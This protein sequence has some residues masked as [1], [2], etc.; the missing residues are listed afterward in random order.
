MS[1]SH[2]T[3]PAALLL[4]SALLF[5]AA[6]CGDDSDDTT[7]TGTSATP[8]ES[9][10]PAGA[11]LELGDGV[12]EEPCPNAIDESH[13]CI[14]LGV[15]SDLTEGP[16]AQQGVAV[17]QGA[18]AFWRRVNEA[19]GI[20]GRFE[21]DIETYTRDNKYSPEEQVARYREMAPNILA[22]AT[23]L[24]TPPTLA[25]LDLYHQDSM[26]VVPAT[27][28]SGWAFQGGFA[29]SGYSYCA[30]SMN[31]LDW[32]N[33]EFGPIDSV[34]AIHYPGDYGGDSAAGARV[35]AE[36][37]GVEFQDGDDLQ[38]LPNASAGN[39]DAAVQALLR[40]NPD[41]VMLAVGPR[42]TAEIVGRADAQGYEGRFIGSRPSWVGSLLEGEASQAII[43]RF[44]P[45]S[46]I[47]PWGTDNAA[48]AAMEEILGAGKVPSN[49]SFLFGW[50]WQYP[51]QALLDGAFEDGHLTREALT[52][53]LAEGIEVDYEGMMPDQ[54]VG[55]DPAS[56]VMRDALILQP[57]PANP[58]GSEVAEDFFI[59]DTAADFAFDAPCV[60]AG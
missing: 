19:G 48:N 14:Y 17:Q 55:G 1:K 12:T 4:A 43:D 56:A 25:G 5:G 46:F 10:A 51:V 41:V 9:T 26:V 23:S 8:G 60:E 18:V 32:A 30:E 2:S 24:G 59:G 42:E 16:F 44:N 53:A 7:S 39:Q 45:V 37:N 47:E 35:W 54:V 29:P 13:G 15:L 57:D 28:W 50:M 31:G 40:R 34:M 20:G 52:A 21:V 6:A 3:R 38:T 33:D 22:V 49:D 36:A 27:F 58:L 11:E